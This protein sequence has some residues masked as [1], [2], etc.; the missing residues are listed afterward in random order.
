[1]VSRLGNK[2]PYSTLTR[3]LLAWVCTEA[4]RTQSP[5]LVLGDSLAEFMLK[6]DLYSTSGGTTGGR[7][8]LRN[9]TRAR[10]G[11]ARSRSGKIFSTRSS[12]TRFRSTCTPS[13]V[14]VD[15]HSA[16]TSTC[17]SP[18][19]MFGLQRLL[20]LTWRQALRAVRRRPGQGERDAHS[21]RL[22]YG[23]SARVEEN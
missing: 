11:T 13:R 16:S 8:R 17:G 19:R 9:Q 23:L 14:S 22:S 12:V 15:L 7:K 10:C 1:M 4:V 2:L 20:R 3:L 18:Y 6:L 5:E 21:G